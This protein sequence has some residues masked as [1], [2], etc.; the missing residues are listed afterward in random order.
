M[1]HPSKTNVG[2]CSGRIHFLALRKLSL[3]PA[4]WRGD[5]VSPS[6]VQSG[7]SG[8]GAPWPPPAVIAHPQRSCVSISGV[9]AAPRGQAPPDARPPNGSRERLIDTFLQN[10]LR[11]CSI[12]H[13]FG[14]GAGVSAHYLAVS[15]RPCLLTGGEEMRHGVGGQPSTVCVEHSCPHAALPGLVIN[16]RKLCNGPFFQAPSSPPTS[17]ITVGS[18]S[19]TEATWLVLHVRLVRLCSGSPPPPRHAHRATHKHFPLPALWEKRSIPRS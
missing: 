8:G 10:G 15:L 1:L 13:R 4:A 12:P 2:P 5:H 18:L 11:K 19:W 9:V 6:G 14:E 17:S 16:L 7:S 3:S